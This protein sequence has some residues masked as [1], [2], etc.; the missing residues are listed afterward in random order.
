MQHP[1]SAETH[2]TTPIQRMIHFKLQPQG[3]DYGIESVFRGP[4]HAQG[5][6]ST[7]VVM[8]EKHHSL[9]E[10][11]IWHTGG[12][13][14]EIPGLDINHALTPVW[15]GA[16]VFLA[17]DLFAFDYNTLTANQVTFAL[18]RLGFASTIALTLA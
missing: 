9:V 14:Q 5:I 18:A 1:H 8:C 10:S 13:N 4:V 17:L 3:L 2:W 12:C 15:K 16:T 11:W 6:G 7:C